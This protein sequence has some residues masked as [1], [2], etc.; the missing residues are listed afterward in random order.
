MALSGP[1]PGGTTGAPARLIDGVSDTGLRI[2]TST[3]TWGRRVSLDWLALL[4]ERAALRGLTPRGRTSCGGATR[5][6]PSA[7]GWLAVSLPRRSDVESLPAWF[8]LVGASRT[9]TGSPWDDLAA[10]TRTVDSSV[11]RCAAELLGLA[12]GVLGEAD[13]DAAGGVAVD[14]RGPAPRSSAPTVVDLGSL[15]AAPLC[16]S[17]LALGGATVTKVESVA[18]PDLARMGDPGLFR[19]L[20]H[21]KRPL[22]LDLRDRSALRRLRE[23]LARADVVVESSRPRAL[24]QM[25]IDADEL[26]SR[27]AGPSV[28]VSIT[29][30]GR[31][32]NRVAFGDD[33]AV[34]GGLVV[35]DG[36]GPWFCGDA[37]ADPLS[38][39][40]AA[41]AASDA[42]ARGHRAVVD[43][44]MA[45]VAAAHAGPTMPLTRSVTA[46][47]PRARPLPEDVGPIHPANRTRLP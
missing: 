16:G 5:L 26:M 36:D 7:D 44:S 43:V 1:L 40:A 22:T 21:G 14:D 17:I 29:G 13:H 19:L 46:S 18:R 35:N 2:E 12:V 31:S 4:G 33:A 28:W 9:T 37:I 45:G 34:A 15:W 25:G 20:D 8:G 30:H 27:P 38:G 6:L 32:S 24:A 11:L 23:L 10:V 42:L 3:A 39:L 47:P 41:A